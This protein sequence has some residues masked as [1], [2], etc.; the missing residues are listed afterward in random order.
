V[1][2]KALR[3]A[4]W[5]ICVFTGE[6]SEFCGFEVGIFVETNASAEVQDKRA[7]IVCLH[8][9]D[10]P[11][12]LFRNYQG[13][14]IV[15][16]SDT[17][18]GGAAVDEAAFYREAP[19]AKFL[20]DFYA[21][22]ALYVARD[23]AEG[24]RQQQTL[25]RQAKRISEAFNLARGRDEKS[26]T[27][28]QL[29]IEVKFPKLDKG[30]LQSIPNTAEVSGTFQTLGLFGLMP[31]MER[32]RLP[33][34]TWGEL[35]DACRGNFRPDV[36]W[37][38][39]LER[40]MVLAANGKSV[41]TAEATF[42]SQ[43]KIYQAI[44]ARR[45]EFFS[46]LQVYSILFVE[47]LP[48][49][50][51]GKKNTSMLLAGLVMA[52]RFR[53]KYLEDKDDMFEAR[54]GDRLSNDDFGA[55]CRQLKYDLED[56]AHEAADFGL[57]DPT[58]FI[59]SFGPGNRAKAESFLDNWAVT[60]KKL[61]EALPPP[62]ARIGAQ[63]RVAVKKAIAEFFDSVEDENERFIVAAIDMFRAETIATFGHRTDS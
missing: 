62:D 15:T 24:T 56:M 54:F 45:V 6:Q 55:N 49:Q 51:L 31:A 36:P 44:L 4:D 32:E 18:P 5:L 57:L 10:K 50:F 39:K 17:G 7:R 41:G 40:D 33:R 63:N 2:E 9:V 8:N 19:I 29:G 1:L 20:N 38:E 58:T 61:Y 30:P 13:R 21:Y 23:A 14:L 47:T 53:F 43:D 16:P 35:R 60:E 25:V 28:T 3:R 27:P 11:P 42:K 59:N 37:M 52:S 22:K 46:G 48:R 12:A 26:S 34:T